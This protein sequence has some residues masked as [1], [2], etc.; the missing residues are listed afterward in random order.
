VHQNAVVVNTPHLVN[1][2][3]Y[4]ELYPNFEL[5]PY[6]DRVS[7]QV[8]DVAKVCIRFEG[9]PEHQGER[10]WVLI[11]TSTDGVYTGTVDNELDHTALHGL[12]SG[13]P[14]SFDYRHIYDFERGPFKNSASD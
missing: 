7:L 5:L 8:G 4:S 14:I 10:F 3:Q 13:D 11:K 2:V 6:Q 12:K 1:A 9:H